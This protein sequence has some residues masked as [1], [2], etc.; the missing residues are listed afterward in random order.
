VEQ[1]AMGRSTREELDRIRRQVAEEKPRLDEIAHREAGELATI[2]RQ[3]RELR[4]S[5]GVSLNGMSERS[6]MDKGYLSRLENGHRRPSFDTITKYARALGKRVD[7][8][9]VDAA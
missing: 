6:G 5:C 8:V 9:F 4:E 1:I 2:G 7:L 3:L